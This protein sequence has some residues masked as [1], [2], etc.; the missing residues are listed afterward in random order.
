MGVSGGVIGGTGKG[1]VIDT[2]DL[3][4]E[5][6]A[7]PMNPTLKRLAPDRTGAIGVEGEAFIR[8]RISVDGVPSEWKVMLEHPSGYALGQ[9]CIETL[10]KEAWHAPVGD[11]G[12]PVVTRVLYRC[13]Y[14]IRY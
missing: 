13:G 7:P 8:L 10:K 1:I 14:E 6:L 3:S 4:R 5:P 12:K 9:R 2:G 11:D